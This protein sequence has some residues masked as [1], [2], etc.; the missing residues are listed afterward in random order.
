MMQGLQTVFRSVGFGGQRE[1]KFVDLPLLK[2]EIR[3]HRIGSI[4]I[5]MLVKQI[6]FLTVDV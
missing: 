2:V 3:I 6:A 5:I 1:A 4:D